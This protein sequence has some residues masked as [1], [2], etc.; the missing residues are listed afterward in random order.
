[1]SSVADYARCAARL[2]DAV[3]PHVVCLLNAGMTIVP[4]FP[5]NTVETRRWMRNILSGTDASHQLHYLDVPDEVCLARLHARNGRGDHPFAVTDQHFR[6][7]THHFVPPS[8]D[9]GFNIVVHRP[10]DTD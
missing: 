8:P 7:I 5:A 4:D 9:E 2:R 10:G 1:M 3:G 6:Q